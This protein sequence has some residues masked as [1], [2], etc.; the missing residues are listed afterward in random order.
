MSCKWRC[1]RCIKLTLRRDSEL[2]SELTWEDI[3][4]HRCW[5]ADCFG[6][7]IEASNRRGVTSHAFRAWRQL[8]ADQASGREFRDRQLKTLAHCCERALWALPRASGSAKFTMFTLFS[9]T[10]M[11]QNDPK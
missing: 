4:A 5:Q 1:R 8:V 3:H 10:K 11:I 6:R 9:L 2:E 7:T